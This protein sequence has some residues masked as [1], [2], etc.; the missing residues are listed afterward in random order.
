MDLSVFITAAYAIS[1]TLLA[2]LCLA[3][4]ARARRVKKRLSE[5]EET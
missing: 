1:G 4:W 2:G 3:T 5:R